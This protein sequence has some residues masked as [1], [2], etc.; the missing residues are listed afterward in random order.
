MAA[1]SRHL[2]GIPCGIFLLVIVLSSCGVPQKEV[3]VLEDRYRQELIVLDSQLVDLRRT[4]TALL[5]DNWHKQGGLDAYAAI[6][7]VYLNRMD[8]LRNEIDRLSRNSSLDRNFLIALI[9]SLEQQQA[10]E[11]YF[12]QSILGYWSRINLPVLKLAAVL[13][14]SLAAEEGV[15]VEEEVLSCRIAIPMERFFK[16]GSTQVVEPA[17]MP[18]LEKISQ[19]LQGFPAF[20]LQVVGHTDNAAQL[21]RKLPDNWDMS[22][23]RASTVTKV[24]TEDFQLSPSRV[25]TAGKGE[26]SPRQSNESAEGK[27]KNRRIEIVASLRLEDIL[28]E[29][30]KLLPR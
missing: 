22:V 21:N 14:D 12:T 30:R 28:R 26:F 1:S 18:L 13:R 17:G 29:Y 20:S 15:E 10:K 11:G 3:L 6:Q 2:L 4:N 9:D 27:A 23:L 16:G 8:S 24:L 19:L 25:L 7:I 5:G